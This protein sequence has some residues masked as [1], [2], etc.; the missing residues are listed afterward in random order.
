VSRRSG[1][2]EPLRV[3]VRVRP[4]ASRPK[5]G[6]RYGEGEPPVLVVAVS[7]PPVDGKANDAVRAALAEAFHLKSSAVTLQ[8][9]ASSRLKVFDLDG[10]DPARLVE[11][12]DG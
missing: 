11:L 6:G 7:A 4:G 2:R 10:A 1:G 12:L 5:V 3:T 8:V 9:G